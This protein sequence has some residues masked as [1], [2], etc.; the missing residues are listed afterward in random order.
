[1]IVAIFGSFFTSLAISYAWWTKV[2]IISLRQDIYD[3]RDQ[4]FDLSLGFGTLEDPAYRATRRHLNHVAQTVDAISF[5]ML[6][7][8]ASKRDN[9]RI[10][11]Q[12]TNPQ[13]QIEIEKTLNWCARRIVNS[14]LRET[15][16]GRILLFRS[17]IRGLT[18][19]MEGQFIRTIGNTWLKSFYPEKIDN[20]KKP[21][22]P[23]V[24][25]QPC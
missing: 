18:S 2:R 19:V 25:A 15:F 14:L 4:L 23:T 20:Y 13:L 1:M 9:E 16:L 3:K 11:I 7:Y 5:D 6:M 17:R 22:R 12:S 21:Q 10:Q 24:V 8:A